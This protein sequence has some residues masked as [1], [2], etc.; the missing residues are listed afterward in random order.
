MHLAGWN[1]NG[2]KSSLSDADFKEYLRK[3]DVI[4]LT[5]THHEK[6]ANISI[7]GL[8]HFDIPAMKLSKKGRRSGGLVL[9]YK[10]EFRGK[11]FHI[12]SASNYIMWIH[13]EKGF[14]S[15][16]EY[17][18]YLAVIYAKPNTL[19][20]DNNFYNIL[21]REIIKFSSMGKL[22]LIGDFNARTGN[23]ADYCKE[24]TNDS[25]PLP[26]AYTFDVTSTRFNQDNTTTVCG[27]Q[28]LDLCKAASLRILNGRTLGDSRG[29]FTCYKSKG[30]SVVDYLIVDVALMN[31]VTYFKV[32][33]ISTMS[34]HCLIHTKFQ[35]NINTCSAYT[36]SP[37]DIRPK[38]SKYVW[39]PESRFMYESAL[40]NDDIQ[41]NT[42]NFLTDGFTLNA[43]GVN[44]AINN[45]TNIMKTAGDRSL[46]K[47][48]FKV[49]KSTKPKRKHNNWFND[50]CY[51]M[52]RELRRLSQ[53]LKKFPFD[54]SLNIEYFKTIKIYRKTLKIQKRKFKDDM[55]FELNNMSEKD[56][57][58]FWNLL[59]K[60]KHPDKD[61][62]QCPA[63]NIAPNEWVTHFKNISNKS[64]R[65]NNHNITNEINELES[66]ECTD[67]FQLINQPITISEIKNIIKTLKSNKSSGEDMISYEM[68][69]SGSTILLPSLAKLFNIILSSKC[70]PDSW[71]VSA[72][73]PLHKKGS[74]FDTDNYRGISITSCLGKCFTALM[75]NRLVACLE[76]H[77]VFADNQAAF[78]KDRRTTDH[79]FTLRS[80]INKYCLKQ[81]GKLYTCFVDFR[82]AFDSVWREA[83]LLKLL[84]LGVR[85]NFYFLLKSMY[86]NTTACV[87]LPAGMTRC[88]DMNLGIRQGDCLSPILFNLFINDISSCFNDTCDPI[89]VGNCNLNYLL[90]ADDLLLMSKSE[91]GLQH[92]INKLYEYSTEWCLDINITKTKVVI[93]Q[94]YGKKPKPILYL[95][96]KAIEIAK[97]YTYLG[98]TFDSSC[99][100]K[101]AALD[102]KVKSTKASFYLSSLLSS[103]NHLHLNTHMKLFDTLIRPILTYG[104]EVW[105]PNQYLKQAL[106]VTKLIDTIPCEK[107]HHNFCKRLLGVYKSCANALVRYELERLPLLFFVTIQTI[108]FWSHIVSKPRESL[109]YQS[110]LSEIE[111]ES[112][113]IKFIKAA[114]YNYN[115][116]EYWH[117]QSPIPLNCIHLIKR[118]KKGFEFDKFNTKFPQYLHKQHEDD[119]TPHPTNYI[120][121]NIKGHIKRAIAKLRLQSNR[122]EIVSGRFTRPKTP[123]ELRICKSC[124]DGV[125]DEKHFLLHCKLLSDLRTDLFDAIYGIYPIFINLSDAEKIRLILHPHSD[126]LATV[127]GTFIINA[128]KLRNI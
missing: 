124:K 48:C 102:L 51:Q 100:F 85:G 115:L 25:I 54:K 113:W 88:F 35:F 36:S 94:R 73:T 53:E 2:L 121:F 71:N 111:N 127:I 77:K 59:E 31:K 64:E 58:L 5:E 82:K 114:L 92:S 90:F 93:F 74:F 112:P 19:R 38:W 26:G 65:H 32:D 40:L 78:R 52:K 70:F 55:L 49:K 21:E 27:K 7:K 4:A 42:I 106:P 15:D 108:K 8:N 118:E 75:T 96:N 61:N 83:M 86:Q 91:I 87:K 68:I 34:D 97:T 6:G 16:L 17:D 125:D 109:L 9:Y 20:A 95:G 84:R 30:K 116:S 80:I 45:F 50:Q 28:L 79:I 23:L 101:T 44:K 104:S 63:E 107:V 46:G 105:L 122:L 66:M 120:N 33:D 98:I 41:Q 56:P 39:T 72:I 29:A 10:K 1:I 119:T 76:K 11:L 14:F 12:K 18:I 43:D 37:N 24:H 62:D 89:N 57:K 81:R 126:E 128:F 69:K 22:A 47:R 67:K 3:F 13:F 123:P 99:S 60:M 117:S 103:H 110:Y